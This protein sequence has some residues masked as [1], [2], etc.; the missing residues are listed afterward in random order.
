MR[1]NVCI[2][3]NAEDR[4]KTMTL[5]DNALKWP[6]LLRRCD[7]IDHFNLLS[8]NQI[9]FW[10]ARHMLTRVDVPH[11]RRRKVENTLQVLTPSAAG[12]AHQRRVPSYHHQTLSAAQ[13]D[14]GA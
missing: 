13:R 7:C 2:N 3:M 4:L 9:H 5:S 1:Y 11:A 6:L 14:V 12:C 10:N 8:R